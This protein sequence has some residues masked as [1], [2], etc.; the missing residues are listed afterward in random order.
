MAEWIA[1]VATSAGVLVAIVSAIFA[2]SEYRLAALRRLAERFE[3]ERYRDRF[4][5]LSMAYREYT[6]DVMLYPNPQRGTLDAWAVLTHD[7]RKRLV[8]PLRSLGEHDNRLQALVREA[9]GPG[10]TEDLRADLVDFYNLVRRVVEWI[11][12][13]RS[14]R[15]FYWEPDRFRAW[16]QRVGTAIYKKVCGTRIRSWDGALVTALDF[17]GLRGRRIGWLK[18]RRAARALNVLGLEFISAVHDHRLLVSKLFLCTERRNGEIL[19]VEPSAGMEPEQDYYLE[20]YGLYDYGYSWMTT[21]LWES[22]R[23]QAEMVSDAMFALRELEHSLAAEG[24]RD[25]DP[26]IDWDRPIEDSAAPAP[27]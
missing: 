9:L 5:R 8:T 10:Y 12:L 7:D 3:S 13:Y 11:G 19:S 15:G 2:Y 4:W 25:R 27:A 22:G 14:L 1:A 16:R 21:V 23:D 17:L 24:L 6:G 20:A 26:W 18:R